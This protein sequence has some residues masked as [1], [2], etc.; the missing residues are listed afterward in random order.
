VVP[1][2][3]KRRTEE[4]GT[5]H[6]AQLLCDRAAGVGS[7][8]RDGFVVNARDRVGAG[9]RGCMCEKRAPLPG[10]CQALA[11]KGSAPRIVDGGQTG[12]YLMWRVN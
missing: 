4:A 3:A 8:A 5:R 11:E 6:V 9:V 2:V 12:V 7:C 1:A 10:P